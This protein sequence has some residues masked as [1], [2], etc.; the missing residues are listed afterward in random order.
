MITYEEAAKQLRYCAET[1]KIFWRLDSYGGFKKSV[2]IHAKDDEAGCTREDGRRTIR[3][4]DKLI[5][6]YRLA[7]LLHYGELPYGEVDHINGLNNDDRIENLRVVT[8]KMNQQ[9]MRT[10]LSNK[11]SCKL[12]GVY[13]NKT[14]RSKPWRAAITKDGK[15]IYL[16][17][18]ATQE[19]AYAAYV[20]AKRLMHEGCTL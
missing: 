16:G 6:R 4:N 2:L 9:N 11:K 13:K 8:R 7:W 18:F 15:Q 14:G 3:I 12:L 20:T 10:T 17:A 19:A 1:G 5:F